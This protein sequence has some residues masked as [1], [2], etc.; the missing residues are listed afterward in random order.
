MDPYNK[1]AFIPKWSDGVFTRD[2]D[3]WIILIMNGTV[4]HILPNVDADGMGHTDTV[5]KHI[6]IRGGGGREDERRLW[7]KL[8][9]DNMK[10]IGIFWRGRYIIS[11]GMKA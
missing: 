2:K 6:Y 3:K 1:S 10:K 4:P 5:D 9:N 8:R 11:H 7:Y